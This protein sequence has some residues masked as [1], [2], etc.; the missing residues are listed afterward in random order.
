[1]FLHKIILVLFVS[2]PNTLDYMVLLTAYQ[3]RGC[4]EAYHPRKSRMKDFAAFFQGWF[5]LIKGNVIQHIRYIITG[6]FLVP[7][8]KYQNNFV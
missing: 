6:L 3:D 1:M 5:F 4:I 8:L 2:S 7:Y